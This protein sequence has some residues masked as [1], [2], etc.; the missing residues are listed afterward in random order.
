MPV[1]LY[2]PTTPGR[3]GASV[4]DKTVLTKKEPEKSLTKGMKKKAGR[5]AGQITVRHK[6]GGEKR[7]YRKIDFHQ[8]KFDI[9]GKV[10]SIEYDP[11]RSAFIALIQYPDG[12]KRYILAQEGLKVG[13]EI[14]SSRSKLEIKT[15]YRLPLKFIPPGTIVSNVELIKGRGGQ[16]AKAAGTGAMVMGFD[17][18]YAQI[19]LP[20]GE[21]RLVSE[22]C[23][24]SIGQMSNVDR[25]LIRIGKAGRKRHLGI[26][27]SVRGKA[28]SPRHHPHGGGEGHTPIGLVH[29]K[30]LWGKP[31]LG[32][33]TRKKKKWSDRFIIK[34]RK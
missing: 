18:G 5:S 13:D 20:S 22:D 25:W 7:L 14:I 32:V 34:R 4:L 21:I 15:G 27:P 24:A 16:I 2:K 11:N 28:M 3:R 29:P 8:D 30:T 10:V 31:A 9:P 6:G 12:E 33:K 1:K 26:R 19:K 17:K 23:L